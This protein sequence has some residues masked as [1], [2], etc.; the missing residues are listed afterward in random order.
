M[1]SVGE[2]KR[3]QGRSQGHQARTIT[4]KETKGLWELVGQVEALPTVGGE[5]VEA[6]LGC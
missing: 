1:T 6:G 5:M 2:P 4:D 3:N